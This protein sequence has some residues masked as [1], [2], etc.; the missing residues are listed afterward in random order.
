MAKPTPQPDDAA[1]SKRF[2]DMAEQLRAEGTPAQF[3]RA[4]KQVATAKKA[5]PPTPK[6]REKP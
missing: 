1:Q 6:K 4:F 3:E 2:M 5:M